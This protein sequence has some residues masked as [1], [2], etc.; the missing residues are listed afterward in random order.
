MQWITLFQKETKENWHNKK[1][2]WVPIVFIMITIMDPITNYYLPEIINMAGGLPDGAVFEMPTLAPEEVIM[3][4]IEQLSMFGVLIIAL[5]S[6]GIIA[7]E[8]NSGV[9]EIILVKPIRYRNYITA[10]W[11]TLLLLVWLALSVGMFLS[12]YYTNLLF[13]D[14][15]FLMLLQIIFFYGLWLTFV[16]TVSV[17][18]NT[19]FKIPGLVAACTILTVIFMSII[20]MIF[21]HKLTWFPNQLSA[22]IHELVITNTVSK[23]LIGTSIITL[24]LTIIIL[25]AAI[26]LF[27]RKEIF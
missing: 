22:H 24:S 5:M 3:M 21:G 18:F 14:I 4:S 17:F 13:G 10:K 26:V 11:T 7:A 20:N 6:M 15:S 25:F 9:T 16:L 27:Q 23:E 1:W 12:W 2:V 8:R 19:M